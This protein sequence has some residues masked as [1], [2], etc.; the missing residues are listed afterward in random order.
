M[1]RELRQIDHVFS[2]SRIRLAGL[3]GLAG[4]L[5]VAALPQAASADR[6][7]LSKSAKPKAV[8]SEGGEG[9]AA[10]M[11]IRVPAV[12]ASSADAAGPDLEGGGELGGFDPKDLS[13]AYNQ[14]G[15]GY[16]PSQTVAIVDAYNDPNAEVDMNKYR[17]KYELYFSGVKTA[18]SQGDECFTE[19]NQKGETKNYPANNSTWSEEISLDLDMVSAACPT[20]HILLVEATNQELSNLFAANEEAA[21][22]E[23]TTSKRK[24]TAISNSWGALEY[25]GETS[26]DKYFNHP[27]IPTFAAGGD[28][29]WNSCEG[30]YEAGI[31][32]PAASPYVVAVGGTK[33]KKEPGSSRKWSEEVWSEPSRK[34]ATG[35]GCSKYEP[36]PQ[37]QKELP[38]KD[39][40]CAHRLDNDVAADAS[41]ESPV[42]VYDSYAP[43][44]EGWMNFGGTSASTPFVAGV[45]AFAS[46][47]TKLLG[48]DAFYKKPSM[49]FDVTKGSNI[50]GKTFCWVPAEDEFFCAAQV[51]YDGPT[52]EGTPDNVFV[53][54]GPT[55]ATGFATKVE[56]KGATLNGILNS[57]ELLG[58]PKY[59]FEYGTTESYGTK[60]TEV[61]LGMGL[62]DR[63]ESSAITGLTKSTTYDFRM[64]T[65][66]SKGTTYGLNQ[67]FTTL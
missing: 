24:A 5:L 4:V 59:Y 39:S 8:C 38:T 25:S 62:E 2:Q 9:R 37:G 35:S 33:L 48:A 32:Y 61:S 34:A 56:E 26:A 12:P 16:G 45:D 54:T 36:K 7:A 63:N 42:S 20:C 55:A 29:G 53:S 65:T 3:I 23:E 30:K 47:G 15:P 57:N 13:E 40:Y 1:L 58:E 31:C 6:F 10:C 49:L 60:T 41:V 14:I 21:K 11:A 27:G 28:E 50:T 51:G 19:I 52:G 17:E 43:L 22:W 66:D 18:C 64:V 46:N 67:V 44:G